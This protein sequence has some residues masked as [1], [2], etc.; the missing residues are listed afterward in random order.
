MQKGSIEGKSTNLKNIFLQYAPSGDFEVSARVETSSRVDGD[1]AF[2]IIWGDH[3]NFVR[4]SRVSGATDQLEITLERDDV[5]EKQQ[6]TV[7]FFSD[8]TL[9]IRKTGDRYGFSYEANNGERIELPQTVSYTFP[10]AKVGFGANSP[11]AGS[12]QKARL[13]DFQIIEIR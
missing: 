7:P 12:L 1:Q 3:N 9:R 6:L 10:Q 2:L 4:F 5:N 13:S 11:Q 8:F